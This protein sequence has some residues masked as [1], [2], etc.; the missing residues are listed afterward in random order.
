MN[1]IRAR[2]AKGRRVVFVGFIVCHVSFLDPKTG[3]QRLRTLLLLLLL[4]FL[5]VSDFQFPKAQ[6]FLNR[7]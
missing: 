3:P 2:R 5:L 4:G 1:R 7:S 6:S